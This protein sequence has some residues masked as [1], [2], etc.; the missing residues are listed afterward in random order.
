MDSFDE[1]DRLAGRPQRVLIRVTPGIKASTHSFIQT[2]QAD[3][4]FGFPLADVERAVERCGQ[5]GL[6]V[7]GLH[8]H[9]GS[10]VFELAAF[11]AV[12]EV[13]RGLGDWPLLNLGG[14]LGIAYTAQDEPP[15]IESYAEALLRH[16]PARREGA[17][18][19]GTLA[20]GQRRRDGLHR[21]DGQAGGR[22]AHLGRRR[23]RHVGQPAPD[24]LRRALRGRDP[25]TA[26]A[27]TRCARSWA[28][29]A[30]P[31]TCW[32]ATSRS[33]DPRPGDLLVIPATGAYG[34]SMANNYNALRRPPVVFCRDGDAR[35]VV[36]RETFDDLTARDV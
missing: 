1:I 19:A 7:R 22:R 2:G 27:A 6:E 30:S 34:H 26:S 33:T 14:G 20:R 17:L 35:L 36:R 12:A 3:S 5:A 32:S 16:A 23:R 15:S 4:K 13:L 8:A 31:A 24:A 21:R 29:T 25:R 11:E 28:C 10:Q 18:R 9:I